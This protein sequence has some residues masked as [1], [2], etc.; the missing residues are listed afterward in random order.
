MKLKKI[1]SVLLCVLTTL[2]IASFAVYAEG[3]VASIGDTTYSTLAEAVTAANAMD[4]D[5]TITLLQ[6][7]TF[8]QSMTIS[9]N[10][11]LTRDDAYTGTLFTVNADKSL[12][13]NDLTIDGNNNWT[14]DDEAFYQAAINNV[15]GKDIPVYYTPEENAPV[16]TEPMIVISGS[17]TLNNATVKNNAG[18]GSALGESSI[19]Y[20]NNASSLTLTGATITHCAN[21]GQNAVLYTTGNKVII[22]EG[23]LISDNLA[24]SNGSVMDIRAAEMIMNGGEIILSVRT[25]A[26]V[27]QKVGFGMLQYCYPA[28]C[29]LPAAL[30]A[31]EEWN[32]GFNHMQFVRASKS[33]YMVKK[34]VAAALC[35]GVL[36]VIPAL[37]LILI[38]IVRGAW[39]D[40]YFI[41]NSFVTYGEHEYFPNVAAVMPQ[42]ILNELYPAMRESR[43]VFNLDF[44][45]RYA[46]MSSLPIGVY[47]Q[48]EIN[49]IL[50][51]LY[52]CFITGG[53]WGLLGLAI[54]A[55]I[56]NRYVC[57]MI[58]MGMT[59]I[60]TMLMN[61]FIQK[62]FLPSM[63]LSIT[64]G[65]TQNSIG[66]ITLIYIVR[67]VTWS[68]VFYFGVERRVHRA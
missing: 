30:I 52:G 20:G 57:M 10:I 14:F 7:T 37:V 53:T 22:N 58:P 5:V 61:P 55:W 44:N 15:T 29:A 25:P 47:I 45:Y 68:L 63:G 11:T 21:T 64:G 32:S 31:C 1:S 59:Y 39:S 66:L 12:T 24:K 3:D 62:F 34:I 38:P 18:T 60:V 50:T 28:L 67:M 48:G 19:F 27:A 9:N 33:K 42:R 36:M 41:L 43:D 6:D 2:V 40:P 17:V 13:L 23:T 46:I 65:M 26:S 16:A 8:N 49:I 56:P 51:V 54:S 4:G 35:G